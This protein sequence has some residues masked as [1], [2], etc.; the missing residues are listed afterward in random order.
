ME[1]SRLEE[2]L[3]Y[4]FANRALLGRAMT[5]R[6][7]AHEQVA[8]GAESHV[9]TLHNEALEFVGD[10]VLGLIVADWLFR[11][12]PEVTE[13]ELSR[14][15]HSLV[16][17]VTLAKAAERL[18]IGRFLRI[19]R[20]EEKTGGRRKS[21]LLADAFEAV[22]AAIFLDGGM[23]AA[24]D[25]LLRALGPELSAT[26]PAAAANE[27]F[28]TKLQEILQARRHAA[29]RYEVTGTEGPPHRRTF[30]VAVIWPDGRAEA[31]GQ[32]IKTA[33]M[34]AARRALEMLAGN[35]AE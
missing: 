8:P 12:Y 24:T 18:D 23:A 35:E 22:L 29:P 21:A 14:M 32:T 33:E 17:A 31:S 20:G 25:F 30:H 34:H 13:G 19:G 10:S 26:T 9:R 28:K 2:T 5:H 3:G 15:K 6:S 1:F 4:N 16:S 7:W 27:D 11:A